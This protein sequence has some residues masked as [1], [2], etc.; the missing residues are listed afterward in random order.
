MYF[1]LTGSLKRRLIDELKD[2]FSQHPVYNKVVPFIQAKYSFEERPQ[3]GIIVTN[4]SANKV[5]LSS[6]N[7]MGMID[8]H[9]MLCY[10][11]TPAYPIEWVRED[12]AAL[13]ANNDVFP[14]S[15][16]FYAI[17]ILEA[18][19]N[20]TD[21]G[22]YVID[23]LLTATQEPLLRFQTGIETEAQLQR[24]PVQGTVRMYENGRYQLQ[25]GTDYQVNYS[26]GQVTFLTT[27]NPGARVTADYRY[28]V[29]SIGPVPFYWNTSDFKT[30]PGV[31]LAFGKRA[32]KGDKVAVVVTQD[33]VETARAYGGK[34]ELTFEMNCV[35]QDPTQREEIA[36]LAAMYLWA[37]KKPFLETEGIEVVEISLGGESEEPMDET[38]DIYMYTASMSVQLRADWEQH[39]PMPFTISNIDPTLTTTTNNLVFATLP[40]FAGR[41]SDFE[42]I[43]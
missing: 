7:F 37:D 19:E 9:V 1:Y 17:E 32:R 12:Q 6:D 10:F 38:G 8:S 22:Y 16:G 30:L 4:A 27:S 3:Y 23:P 14:L 26:N 24:I 25:E 11:G 40:M 15:P 5:S 39:V 28:V 34:W 43:K 21:P 13:K 36:D 2:S 20:A 31:V 42:R 29:P 41:N 33:R 18:P 35:A